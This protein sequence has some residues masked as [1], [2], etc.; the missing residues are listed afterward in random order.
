MRVSCEQTAH[1]KEKKLKLWIVHRS[2]ATLIP[3][4]TW[5]SSHQERWDAANFWCLSLALRVNRVMNQ[6][7]KTMQASLHTVT[8]LHNYCYRNKRKHVLEVINVQR[9]HINGGRNNN[10]LS[11]RRCQPVYRHWSD[12]EPSAS[13]QRTDMDSEIRKTKWNSYRE[14]TWLSIIDIRLWCPSLSAGLV[15]SFKILFHFYSGLKK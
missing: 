5:M 8:G 12:G 7:I 13:E 9:L 10:Y 11:C 3:I 4:D 1:K 6:P 2:W 15:A 14:I